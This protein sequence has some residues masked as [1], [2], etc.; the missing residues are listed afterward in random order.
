MQA[1]AGTAIEFECAERPAPGTGD[2]SIT[3]AAGQLRW[4]RV[5]CRAACGFRAGWEPCPCSLRRRVPS[6]QPERARRTPAPARYGAGFPAGN[7]SGRAVP[8]PLLATAQGSQRATRA[9]APYPSP[10]QWQVP[11]P[12]GSDQSMPRVFWVSQ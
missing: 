12:Q 7:Q 8:L 11:P 10:C 3:R 5:P 6:G 9:G 2:R 4:R 1:P